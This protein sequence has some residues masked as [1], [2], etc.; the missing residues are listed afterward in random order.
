M[1]SQRMSAF[2]VL[3]LILLLL[4]GC[5]QETR[6]ETIIIPDTGAASAT[7]GNEVFFDVKTIY[8][9]L[10][11]NTDY[12]RPLGWI[13]PSSLIGLF[14]EQTQTP[15]LDR[16]DA[17]YDSHLKLRNSD[18]KA[19]FMAI[20]PDS[21][22]VAS[23]APEAGSYDL[24]LVSLTD[25]KET[26]IDQLQPIQLRSFMSSWSN[27]SRYLIYASKLSE[28]GGVQIK[29][30]NT[31]DNTTKSY[32]VQGWTP[33]DTLI[34]IY[35]AND[36]QT[37]AIIRQSNKRTFVE[38]GTWSGSE[39]AS[40]YEHLA[41]PDSQVEWIHNDQI[42]FMGN[43]GT[44]YAYDRRNAALSILLEGI[45]AFRLSPDRKSVAYTQEK[46]TVYAATLYGNNVL[47]KTQ[48]FKGTVPTLIE[49]GPDNGRLLLSGWKSYELDPQR[50]TAAPAPAPAEAAEIRPK[51]VGMQHFVIEFN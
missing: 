5:M 45:N 30:Y 9:V 26:V 27:N 31:E 51:S 1:S 44:L 35:V 3:L 29:V 8:R 22:F 34:S 28:K 25:Q 42:A 10:D 6:S 20:S 19:G 50:S 2:A 46:D 23:V 15:S 13:D 7:G 41:A 24:K 43:E 17:P 12:G 16:I 11:K 33:A 37:A 32:T 14:G 4:S 40:Q 38:F 47:N 36:A 21:R 48:L 18:V 49:W 39:L